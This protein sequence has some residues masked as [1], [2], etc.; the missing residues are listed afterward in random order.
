MIK[1]FVSNWVLFRTFKYCVSYVG[2]TLLVS[3]INGCLAEQLES[4]QSYEAQN[5]KNNDS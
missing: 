3:M 4:E 2:A 1:R 5:R